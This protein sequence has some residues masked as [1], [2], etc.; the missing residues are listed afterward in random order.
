MAGYGP[1]GQM[2][3]R[4]A[5]FEAQDARGEPAAEHLAALL[6]TDVKAGGAYQNFYG[7]KK[8]DRVL[9]I[10]GAKVGDISL[11]DQEGAEIA[12]MQA[13]QRQQAIEVERGQ[14]DDPAATGG[15]IGRPPKPQGATL[16]GH[17]FGGFRTRLRFP[18]IAYAAGSGSNSTAIRKPIAPR[19]QRITRP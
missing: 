19:S 12:L 5:T 8:G 17:P 7:L 3:Q 10:G 9:T 13:Y 16:H 1:D 18:S 14:E 11:E 4:S 2:A 15:E 6:A